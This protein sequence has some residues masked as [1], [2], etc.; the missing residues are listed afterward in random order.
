M[1]LGTSSL[2]VVCHPALSRSRRHGRPGRRFAD[3]VEAELHHVSA[4]VGEGQRRPDA[5][6]RADRA[7]QI[8]VVIALVDGLAGSRSAPG[9]PPNLA[10][11][12][13]PMRASS[14]HETFSV[15]RRFGSLVQKTAQ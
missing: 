5:T 3:F 10:V 9:P 2:P 15:K 6:G 11:F 12:F 8:G 14:L 4:G 13:W 1:L 7:E